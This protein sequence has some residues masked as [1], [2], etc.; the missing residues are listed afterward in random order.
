M[1]FIL[2]P[3]FHVYC[4]ILLS[5][6]DHKIKPDLNKLILYYQ[7][8]MNE[9]N[10]KFSWLCILLVEKFDRTISDDREMNCYDEFVKSPN[11]VR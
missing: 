3:I 11:L 2:N 1:F 5:L 6:F 4:T 10:F 8:A 7:S 9:F